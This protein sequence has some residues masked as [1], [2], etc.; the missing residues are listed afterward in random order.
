MQ[1]QVKLHRK[2][3]WVKVNKNGISSTSAAWFLTIFGALIDCIRLWNKIFGT[4]SE[5]VNFLMCASQ[6]VWACSTEYKHYVYVLGVST[7]C[8][9]RVRLQS[10]ST[11]CTV[12]QR[13]LILDW[14]NFEISFEQQHI[15]LNIF[16][17][18]PLIKN[19]GIQF[20]IITLLHRN[21]LR[22]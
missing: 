15:M 4:M 2:I 18:V 7:R 3:P 17:S 14:N 22:F 10:V 11:N 19:I 20:L 13:D 9:H 16:L 1:G 8:K 6:L 21:T 12:L 5:R